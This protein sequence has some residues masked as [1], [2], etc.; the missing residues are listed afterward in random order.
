MPRLEQFRLTIRNGA[1]GGP[2]HPQ[3]EINGFMVDFDEVEGGARPGETLQALG[4]PLSLPHTLVLAGPESGEWDIESIDAVYECAGMSPYT[5][6]MGA[7]TLDENTSLN[8]WHEPPL[9]TFDV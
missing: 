5:V 9:P 1:H 8:I 3:Y 7:V 4:R 2:A 6:R